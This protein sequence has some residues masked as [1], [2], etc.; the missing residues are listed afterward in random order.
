MEYTLL[1]IVNIIIIVIIVILIIK[2]I[3]KYRRNK[4]EGFQN[5]SDNR[6]ED[7]TVSRKEFV[8]LLGLLLD[9]VKFAN[10]IIINNNIFS[11]EELIKQ[12][13]EKV[14]LNV[15][16]IID[17]SD[18][19][20]VQ[21]F[22]D[23]RDIYFTIQKNN[24]YQEIIDLA[25]SSQ[26]IEPSRIY[27]DRQIE[28]NQLNSFRKHYYLRKYL[29]LEKTLFTDMIKFFI[30]IYGFKLV[31]LSESN[32]QEFWN[33]NYYIGE[34]FRNK[35]Q[36]INTPIQ[37]I[38]FN[39]R[40]NLFYWKSI[41]KN[42]YSFQL[43][44]K[45]HTNIV[46]REN[47]DLKEI[48]QFFDELNNIENMNNNNQILEY[49]KKLNKQP[50]PDNYLWIYNRTEISK[51]RLLLKLQE[52]IRENYFNLSQT[53]I[54]QFGFNPTDTGRNR[55]LNWIN[56]I[57]QYI[58]Q[59]QIRQEIQYNLLETIIIYLNSR[60][61]NIFDDFLSYMLFYQ[62]KDIRDLYLDNH[63][64]K[65]RKLG[66]HWSMNNFQD[67]L[68]E[69]TKMGQSVLP[70]IFKVQKVQEYPPLYKFYFNTNLYHTF[71]EPIKIYISTLEEHLSIFLK[72]PNIEQL[73]P[74]ARFCVY[75]N[76]SFRNY[77]EKYIACDQ[78]NCPNITSLDEPS[79]C[80]E[81]KLK[82]QELTTIKN[83][84]KCLYNPTNNQ[85][86]DNQLNNNQL[87]ESNQSDEREVNKNVNKKFGFV[88]SLMLDIIDYA[89]K[90]HKCQSNEVEI[91]NCQDLVTD[92]NIN[93]QPDD[94]NLSTVINDDKND[95]N[96]YY[97]KQLGL[98]QEIINKQEIKDLSKL[99]NIANLAQEINRNK[100]IEN[101]F[102]FKHNTNKIYDMIQDIRNVIKDSNNNSEKFENVLIN[103]LD[104]TNN[105]TTD[106]INKTSTETIKNTIIKIFDI[107]TKDGRM[108][109]SGGIIVFIS[110]CLYFIDIT[111]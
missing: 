27:Q 26:K 84:L 25:L 4:K 80:S 3:Q 103:N 49:P 48:I 78:Q 107:L 8:K 55:E 96:D 104:L 21:R 101:D 12:N 58:S 40:D 47:H 70:A 87:N 20:R 18:L 53:L 62:Y 11:F 50:E 35:I 46:K 29:Y 75:N 10:Q 32:L 42:W 109:T 66:S 14:K 13:R 2:S 64:Q 38:L 99:N 44:G 83:Q 86:N 79:R 37:T 105:K 30:E 16:P 28:N 33:T 97:D 71:L 111:S 90:I 51:D 69:T 22:L 36:I 67:I 93:E 95:L 89:M 100:K 110:L 43:S 19:E 60:V 82:Y 39:S 63:F 76:S 1:K 92:V 45:F 68:I 24:N 5:K 31:S 56:K 59:K 34:Q 15:K 52:M 73:L 85:L 106:T 61:I 91:K 7:E 6:E 77:I 108:M 72:N 98:Y 74:I 54:E 9:D 102:S 94:I 41:S 65:S 23:L 81:I 57:N 17:G 88:N